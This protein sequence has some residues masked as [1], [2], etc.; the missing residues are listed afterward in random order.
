MLAQP[1][2]LPSAQAHNLRAKEG[3]VVLCSLIFLFTFFLFFNFWGGTEE[4]ETNL[5]TA[6]SNIRTLQKEVNQM[7]D[8]NQS[9]E[10]HLERLSQKMDLMLKINGIDDSK[11]SELNDSN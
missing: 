4:V 5:A 6:Q 9:L 1:G 10:V 8:D 7:E 11:I 3:N 2:T